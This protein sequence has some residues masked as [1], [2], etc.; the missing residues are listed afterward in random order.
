MSKKKK[1]TEEKFVEKFNGAAWDE[2][3][4]AETA[5]QVQG[6][7]G[8]IAQEFLDVRKKLF[9]YLDKIGYELG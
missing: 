3:I 7:L 2:E 1:L 4:L 5:S 8:K 6:D 9:D